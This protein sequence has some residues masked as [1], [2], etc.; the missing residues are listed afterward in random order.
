ML[1]FGAWSLAE[2]GEMKHFA[3]G[4][5][6]VLVAVSCE[7]VPG[8]DRAQEVSEFGL[9]DG[10]HG[11]NPH[12]F[13][14]P[15]LVPAPSYSGTFEG[16]L[17]PDV[18]ICP[19][20]GNTC[21]AN[22]AAFDMNTG[23]GSETVRVV[24]EDELYI[25]NWHTG[26]FDLTLGQAYRIWVSVEGVEL[27][28]ADVVLGEGGREAR[29]LTTNETFGLQDGRTLP[30]KFRIEDGALEPPPTYIWPFVCPTDA[31][32]GMPVVITDSVGRMA[33][34]DRVIFAPPGEGP[35]Q[36][37]SVT[38]ITVSAD[39]KVVSASVPGTVLPGPYNIT[40]H[41][42]EP[43]LNPPVFAA[44]AF[45]VDGVTSSACMNPA[46]GPRG[47]T[48][49]ITNPSGQILPGSE[50]V[51]YLEGQDPSVEGFVA[52][53]TV[54]SSTTITGTVPAGAAF[55]ENFVKVAPSR[56]DPAYFDP[57]LFD[58]Q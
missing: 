46:E 10:A 26:E 33:F 41:N 5:V 57:L 38:E 22:V 11:G 58:V 8:P 2:V 34:A 9:L 16:T 24:P 20:D 4:V 21:G 52:V 49:I 1:L 14:L 27:G 39:G 13:F 43:L 25:V 51:F 40:V 15:P 3:I 23:P 48:F 7:D 53:V 56:G 30:I 32:P 55:G 44:I 35:D 19:W 28:Y 29:N 50:V 47:R 37:T 17:N 36:G 54:A 31:G 6:L 18:D 12:F 42:G 45:E